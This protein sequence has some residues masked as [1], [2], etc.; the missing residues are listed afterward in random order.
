MR[1]KG[2]TF[3]HAKLS[4]VLQPW[5]GKSGCLTCSGFHGGFGVV[6][7]AINLDLQ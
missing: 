7:E 4:A 6:V 3:L 2:E 5:E 1:S